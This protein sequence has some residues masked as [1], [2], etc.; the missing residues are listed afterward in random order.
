MPRCTPLIFA[1]SDFPWLSSS[2]KKK[3]SK[4]EMNFFTIRGETRWRDE[5]KP[6]EKAEN[7]TLDSSS[8][9]NSSECKQHGKKIFFFK[10]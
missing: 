7:A 8:E 3:F 2:Q 9:E 4:I 1:K 6:N 10:I 5:F